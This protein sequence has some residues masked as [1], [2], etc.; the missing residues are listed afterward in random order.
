MSKVKGENAA[1]LKW[2]ESLMA[3]VP[4]ACVRSFTF[5]LQTDFLDVSIKGSGKFRNTRPVSNTF[6][7]NLE[8]IVDLYKPQHYTIAEVQ[9]MQINHERVRL[10]HEYTDN[11]GHVYGI[12]AYFYFSAS[13]II[14]SFDN[15]ATFTFDI[16][17]DGPLTQSYTPSPRLNAIVKSIYYQTDGS[18][19]TSFQDNRLIGVEV[20][21]AW[22]Q[23]DF[24]VITAGTPEIL[25]IKHNSAT[26]VMSWVIPMPVPGPGEPVSTWHIQYQIIYEES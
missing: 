6:D 8:G 20:V 2:N 4:F 15:I 1:L 5:N 7:G 11:D 24:E 16:V 13:T 19:E 23:T 26:G 14:S 22:N 25:E 9:A 17:G 10:L 18:E 3:W 21:G 12:D